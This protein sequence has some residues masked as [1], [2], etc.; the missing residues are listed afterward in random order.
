MFHELDVMCKCWMFYLLSVLW[1]FCSDFFHWQLLRWLRSRICIGIRK[2]TSEWHTF[3]RIFSHMQFSCQ[4]N[5]HTHPHWHAS[6]VFSSAYQNGTQRQL[7][8]LRWMSAFSNICQHFLPLCSFICI[9]NAIDI[10]HLVKLQK[11]LSLSMW[12]ANENTKRYASSTCFI[13]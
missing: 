3:Q 13:V 2:K 10:Q 9:P 8:E 11:S 6:F 1:W 12:I 5:T 7:S 4:T